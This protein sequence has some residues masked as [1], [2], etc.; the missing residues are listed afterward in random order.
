MNLVSKKRTLMSEANAYERSFLASL[1]KEFSKAEALGLNAY[2][3]VKRIQQYYVYYAQS[4]KMFPEDSA[5]FAS[6]TKMRI[7]R[8]LFLDSVLGLS[9]SPS[10]FF[11]AMN[12]FLRLEMT[13]RERKHRCKSVSRRV[14]CT[15]PLLH[16]TR[17][18][19]RTKSW[20]FD[21]MRITLIGLRNFLS[22]LPSGDRAARALT[23]KLT[24]RIAPHTIS[25]CSQN[26]LW[27][28]S[29]RGN[30][31]IDTPA[32]A[33]C[34]G[35]LLLPSECALNDGHKRSSKAMEDAFA[36][37]YGRY[38]SLL[39]KPASASMTGCCVAIC[40]LFSDWHNY[41]QGIGTSIMTKQHAYSLECMNACGLL[42]RVHC[43]AMSFVHSSILPQ[44]IAAY[45]GSEES[46][47]PDTNLYDTHALGSLFRESCVKPKGLFSHAALFNSACYTCHRAVER[48]VSNLRYFASLI[49]LTDREAADQQ[50]SPLSSDILIA[51]YKKSEACLLAY[52]S[53]LTSV[54][55]LKYSPDYLLRVVCF[56]VLDDGNMP[57]QF[58]DLALLYLGAKC[59]A[60]LLNGDTDT[61]RTPWFAGG[62]NIAATQ[63]LL[64]GLGRIALRLL[65]GLA[66]SHSGTALQLVEVKLSMWLLLELFFFSE[67]LEEEHCSAAASITVLPTPQ[68]TAISTVSAIPDNTFASIRLLVQTLRLCI[69]AAEAIK[70]AD[71]MAQDLNMPEEPSYYEFLTSN[72]LSFYKRKRRDIHAVMQE[73]I[74]KGGASRG[75]LSAQNASPS[76]LTK[77]LPL[78]I[79]LCQL[80][81]EH[82]C[83]YLL[84]DSFLFSAEPSG[85][86]LPVAALFSSRVL[87][88]VSSCAASIEAKYSKL[89]KQLSTSTENQRTGIANWS[90]RATNKHAT[91]LWKPRLYI[92]TIRA[93]Q[94]CL[95]SSR[96]ATSISAYSACL[97]NLPRLSTH[98]TLAAFLDKKLHD[99]RLADNDKPEYTL[100]P[101]YSWFR[102]RGA[103]A[104]LTSSS[105]A[106]I[107]AILD[108]DGEFYQGSHIQIS[109]LTSAPNC[110]FSCVLEN[111]VALNS[112][113]SM[114]H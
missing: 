24:R 29:T 55:L 17:L 109:L 85:H 106:V 51:S 83:L 4:R 56:S 92:S 25:P 86:F 53:M 37:F 67:R 31:C 8:S 104:F 66:S 60:T 68:N 20:Q 114:S 80:A 61:S 47:R 49:F 11:T 6:N 111:D 14:R 96:L 15:K 21:E 102:N 50:L 64:P 44:L 23:H 81:S 113:I 12:E 82:R 90:I 35:N 33:G 41:L 77:V 76:V 108:I 58:S 18:V 75:L 107:S 57:S 10:E 112:Q 89:A 7:Y 48:E 98:D 70:L 87:A 43:L 3:L 1:I 91:V 9:G 38:R 94:G 40:S 93:R 5:Y 100:S 28:N 95:R 16:I 22:R 74:E 19:L 103:L 84:C 65:Q 69:G 42:S 34:N 45:S 26:L 72:M 88:F 13:H 110:S 54:F 101:V 59:L 36:H 97:R 62:E 71:Y 63:A 27:W 32:A 2:Q 79:P 46:S 30:S 99:A 39:S 73:S 105:L 52:L 78:R